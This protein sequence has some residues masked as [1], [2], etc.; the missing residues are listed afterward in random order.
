MAINMRVNSRKKKSIHKPRLPHPVTGS[1]AFFR[2]GSAAASI[3][4]VEVQA[5]NSHTL[6]RDRHTNEQFILFYFFPY[7]GGARL[8][9]AA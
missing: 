9:S 5:A 2:T 7:I 8:W 1:L 3:V 6:R 4:V